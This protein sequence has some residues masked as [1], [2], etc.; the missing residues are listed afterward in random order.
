MPSRRPHVAA[1][2]AQSELATALVELRHRLELPSG[3]PAGVLREADAA[4]SAITLPELDLT[5]IEFV[6]IDPE[7]STDLDQALHIEPNGT[8][9]RVRYAIADV[10]ALVAPGGAVDDEAR[11]RGQTLYAAD[12]R[13]ALHPPAIGDGAGSLLPGQLRG[14]YV[15]EFELDSD[16][17]QRAATVR[18]ARVRSREQLT[19]AQAQAAIDDG[20]ASETLKLLKVVGQGRIA[21]ERERGGA[22][23]NAPEEE[24]VLRDDAY[25]IQR[26]VPLAVEDWNAQISLLTGMAA[27]ELM[28]AGGVGILRTM[29]PPT[30]DAA[31]TFR[32]QTEA[33]GRPWAHDMP[34]GEYLRTLDHDDPFALAVLQ[35][36]T[37][38]FR[39]AGY[40]VFDGAHPN[41]TMQS[42]VAAPYAHT[43]A[44]LRRLV[45]RW[46]LVICEA[47]SNGRDVPAWARDSLPQL[48]SIMDASSRLS[49]ELNAA[50]LDRV[51]AALLSGRVG[52][53]FS[54]TV[55][56]LRGDSARIQ[57][58]DPFVTA[59][60]AATPGLASGSTV[61]AKLHAVDIATGSI[62]FSLVN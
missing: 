59:S 31:A 48:P 11:K 61:R 36:A 7:G 44:P 51:E 20:S 58:R 21:L 17:R 24:I 4:A 19:Y 62:G 30:E 13:I 40:T 35:A 25:T 18:R 50:S 43:T 22:S 56:A 10:P 29:P 8:G 41:E 42:A 14:A 27:A 12:G 55:I 49:S 60:C 2:A 46:C 57:L 53:V 39:G 16:A 54:A 28:L 1:S 26:R 6:T 15:W 23:L 52:E 33:L 9:F 45:D 3:F 37:T 47:L 38:L 5:T 34:Y 32:T